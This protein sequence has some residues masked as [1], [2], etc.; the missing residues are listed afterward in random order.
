MGNPE[1]RASKIT[2]IIIEIN[3]TEKDHQ[4]D[5]DVK[6]KSWFFK[7]QQIDKR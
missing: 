7:R 2:K 3:I 6:L 5:K 1:T 4:I